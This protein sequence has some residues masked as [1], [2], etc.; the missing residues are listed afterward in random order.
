VG[1]ATVI[2]CLSGIRHTHTYVNINSTTS[3]GKPTSQGG[4]KQPH[5]PPLR[6]VTKPHIG[7]EHY[8]YL[9]PHAPRHTPTPRF[10]PN[11]CSV[12]VLCGQPAT[13]RV[14][15]HREHLT[16][17]SNAAKHHPN[18]TKVL[19]KGVRLSLGWVVWVG[20]KPGGVWWL[21]GYRICLT[22]GFCC[23]TLVEGGG[24]VWSS[25]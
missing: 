18:K 19:L 17:L 9:Y 3:K 13:H 10:R 12:P 4:V 15:T 24:I 7:R 1:G 25:G 23:L 6:V 11:G 2:P 20:K 14:N 8:I 5:T 22:W 21:V 16:T